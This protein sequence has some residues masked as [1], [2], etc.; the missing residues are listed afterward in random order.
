M[1]VIEFVADVYP[2]CKGDVVELS[3]SELKAVDAAAERRGI[4][5]YTKVAAKT[6]AKAV[7][8][9]EVKAETKTTKK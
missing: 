6:E 4:E 9:A 7:D 1:P 3:D 8:K 5:A 2:H